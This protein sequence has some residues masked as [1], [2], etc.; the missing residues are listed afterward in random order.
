MSPPTPQLPEAK[1][2][3]GSIC[4][5][6][7]FISRLGH[8]WQ[9]SDSCFV[10]PPSRHS[11]IISCLRSSSPPSLPLRTVDVPRPPRHHLRPAAVDRSVLL[12][13]LPLQLRTLRLVP[14]VNLGKAIYNGGDT[15]VISVACLAASGLSTAHPRYKD[16]TRTPSG[17]TAPTRGSPPLRFCIN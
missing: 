5:P 17:D 6:R 14:F 8:W 2:C 13:K 11:F 10:Y 9:D 12:G 3:F 1:A 4:D 7:V 16:R 15:L